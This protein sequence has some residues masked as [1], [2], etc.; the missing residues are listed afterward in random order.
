MT[1]TITFHGATQGSDPQVP[2]S[3]VGPF[4]PPAN[5][6]LYVW[7]FAQRTGSPTVSVADSGNGYTYTQRE[8]NQING[9]FSP[10]YRLWE[11]VSTGATPA[12]MTVT[13]TFTANAA[14]AVVVFS[15]TS[16]QIKQSVGSA[17]PASGTTI[18]SGTLSSAAV[19]G[20]LCV[21][22]FG[23]NTDSDA[24]TPTPS[25]WTSLFSNGNPA[26]LQYIR[27]NVF[28]RTDFTGTSVSSTNPDPN[29]YGVALVEFE[30][31]TIP[32][33][34]MGSSGAILTNDNKCILV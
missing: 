29:E 34:L 15:I 21:A 31:T 28:Y 17:M 9:G 26:G 3:V 22:C 23:A 18:N 5:S 8:G 33:L 13:V 2:T 12:A 1:A 14:A 10:I 24:D 32:S 11:V 30:D 16:G 25:G 19:N 7:M 27:S 20:N 6:K 4:T